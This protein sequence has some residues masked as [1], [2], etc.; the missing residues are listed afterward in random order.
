MESYPKKSSWPILV[1]DK[2][3]R[4]RP[5]TERAQNLITKCK[6]VSTGFDKD[7]FDKKVLIALAS[8]STCMAFVNDDCVQDMFDY[9]GVKV[10]DRHHLRCK[11]MPVVLAE[12]TQ[13]QKEKINTAKNL[14]VVLDGWTDVSGIYYIAVL[15]IIDSQSVYIGNIDLDHKRGTGNVI[16]DE[17][18]KLLPQYCADE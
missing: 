1:P 6:K 7:I 10:P 5:A 4:K 11:V 2:E 15:L 16:A 13:E 12:V 8:T 17:V 18:V 9:V 14:N 3:Q